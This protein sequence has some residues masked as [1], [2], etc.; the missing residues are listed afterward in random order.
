MYRLFGW[1]LAG[2]ILL[3]SSAPASAQ[4]AVTVGNPYTGGGL[5]LGLPGG[6]GYYGVSSY[7]YPYGGAPLYSGF[8]AYGAAPVV[9]TTYSSGYAGYVAPA[10]GYLSTGYYGAYPAASVYPYAYRGLGYGGLY[11]GIAPYRYAPYGYGG[12]GFR[13]RGFGFRGW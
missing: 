1:M 13:G 9:G 11:G 12:Y 5:S 8:G 10:T 7:G 2:G 3:G 4:V 6:Y